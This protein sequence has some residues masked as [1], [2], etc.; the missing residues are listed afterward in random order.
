MA[1]KPIRVFY[2]ELSGR[3]YASAHYRVDA[4]GYVVITGRKYDVTNDIGAAVVEHEIEFTREAP[5]STEPD[6]EGPH[7][8]DVEHCEGC[9]S[10]EIAGYDADG[11][12]L[13]PRCI[14][15]LQDRAASTEE[16]KPCP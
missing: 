6:E 16:A 9:G 14:K 15:A 13:C 12:P 3:F 7:P 11:I 4:K 10:T 8:D 2:S 1:A 5:A